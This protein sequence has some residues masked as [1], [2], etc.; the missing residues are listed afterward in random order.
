M[1]PPLL[2]DAERAQLTKTCPDWQLSSDQKSLLASYKFA[3]FKTAFAFMSDMAE[4]SESLDHHPKW[5]NSY[6]RLSIILTT[7][8]VG[9]LTELDVMLA[10]K[11]TDAAAHY[12]AKM[13]SG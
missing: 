12:G 13:V 6:N 8:D 1:R 11:M 10:Q 3:D 7:H 5:T 9:G 2:T 4:A